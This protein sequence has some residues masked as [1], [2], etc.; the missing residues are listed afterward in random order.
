MSF[1]LGFSQNYEIH[2]FKDTR[3]V[4]TRTYVKCPYKPTLSVRSFP[5]PTHLN[6]CPI[7]LKYG[8]KCSYLQGLNRDIF[9]FVKKRIL[10]LSL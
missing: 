3:Q 5:P 1:K 10:E 9:Y 4:P 6:S 7:S 8:A 2:R